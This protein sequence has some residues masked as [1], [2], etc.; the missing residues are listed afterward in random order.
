MFDWDEANIAH[1]ARHG[2]S[3]EESEEADWWAANPE[4]VLR[5]FE[6]AAAGGRL[7]HGTVMRL[8]AERRAAKHV[9]LILDAADIA[10]ANKLA[11]RK[12]LEREAY[13]KQLLHAALAHRS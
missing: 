9:A 12:G 3:P 10:L 7:G 4:F 5:E 13:V 2:V 1:I 6:Q 8:A 11:E